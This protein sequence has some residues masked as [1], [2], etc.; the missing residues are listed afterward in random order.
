MNDARWCLDEA[1]INSSSAYQRS[2][3]LHE[4]GAI[5]LELKCYDDALSCA[6][7]SHSLRSKGRHEDAVTSKI[8]IGKIHLALKNYSTA[9]SILKETLSI[10]VLFKSSLNEAEIH[11]CLFEAYEAVYDKKRAVVQL[12]DREKIKNN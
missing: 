5:L 12:E 7:N 10:T 11:M 6:E 4:L 3:A 8:L 9:I 1:L 2:K